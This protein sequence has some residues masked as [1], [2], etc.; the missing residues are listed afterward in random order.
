MHYHGPARFGGSR[1]MRLACH[2][3]ASPEAGLW[4]QRL[5]HIRPSA[6]ICAFGQKSVRLSGQIR[7]FSLHA[8]KASHRLL[9]STVVV[10]DETS[11]AQHHRKKTSSP[12]LKPM[13]WRGV[14]QQGSPAIKMEDKEGATTGRKKKRRVAP[15]TKR[16]PSAHIYC[17]PRRICRH[18]PKYSA[19]AVI[20]IPQYSSSSAR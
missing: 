16:G 1:Y 6:Q 12:K 17:R 14:V 13:R 9:F 4:A 8:G 11:E 15:R 20:Y 5:P 10:I 7:P 19:V 18:T 2:A 3:D